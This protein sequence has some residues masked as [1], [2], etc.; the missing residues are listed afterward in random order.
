MAIRA[1]I[2]SETQRLQGEGLTPGLA[3]ILVG[4]DAGSQVYVRNK[5]KACAELGW[6]S[7]VHR[8]P[9]ETSEAEVL[10]LVA[11]LNAQE[12]IDGI[13]CQSPVPRHID[14]GKIV[15][16]I[17]PDKDVDCFHPLNVGRLM[18]GGEQHFLPCTP[19]GI[20]QIL[21]RTGIAIS[22][23]HAV[24][25]G[26][27]NIVGKPMAMLL[28]QENATVTICHSHTQDLESITREAD[29]LVVAVGKAQL[30]DARYVKPGA[31]VIDVGMN[32][33][34]NGKLCG[35]V[36][37]DSVF[38]VASY[39]TPVPGGVGVVTITMLLQNTLWAARRRLA[40]RRG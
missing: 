26:R 36:D 40:E 24:V 12:N 25:I 35:D 34:P 18:I 30:I 6:Y 22:G 21:K 17:S 23:K 5:E 38:E 11:K 9:A 10:A 1:E 28:L 33:Q 3:V 13:L 16:T 27:S 15:N 19:A 31:V 29:I 4:D 2:A 39:I 7:E 37:Y 14:E 8:L 32:R 20:I